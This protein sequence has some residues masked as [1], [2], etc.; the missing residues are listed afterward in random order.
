MNWPTE[1][2]LAQDHCADVLEGCYD[3]PVEPKVVLDIGA[4]VGAF[5][6]WASGRWPNAIV[7]SYEPHPFNFSLL[8]MT[9]RHYGLT[10]VCPNERAISDAPGT[11]TLYENGFN[12]GEW[13]LLKFDNHD[14]R[15]VSVIVEDAI[16]LPDADFIKLDTEGMEPNIIKRLLDAGKLEKV[17]G[18]ALEYHSAV[19]VA[20]IIWMLQQAGLSLFHC[21][22][23]MDHRGILKFIRR[24]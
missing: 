8:K 7:H 19:Y 16:N 18:G 3:C 4:N 17:Q 5:A 6:R 21:A 13:S 9:V 24:G 23:H 10:N 20:P 1:F 22:P 15:E 2:N 12:C 14:K 11:L